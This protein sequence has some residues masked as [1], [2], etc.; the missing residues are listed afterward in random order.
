MVIRGDDVKKGVLISIEGIEGC[1]KST[2]ISGLKSGLVCDGHQIIYTR[3]PGGCKISEEIRKTV[4]S[5]EN[6]DIT[7]LTEL[8]MIYA[9]RNEHIDKVI[10]PALKKGHVVITDRYY[11]SSYAYQVGGQKINPKILETLDSWVVKGAIPSLTFLLKVP[12][13]TCLERVSQRGKVDRFDEQGADF[14]RD[15]QM[16]FDRRAKEQPG[17]V[18]VIEGAQSEQAVLDQ[19]KSQIANKV[20]ACYQHG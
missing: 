16:M 20:K 15:V 12:I 5:R 13:K 6:D 14:F 7:A 1:G 19:V 17:R 10:N 4:S 11:D 8:L 18:I 2:L 3:E 9:A